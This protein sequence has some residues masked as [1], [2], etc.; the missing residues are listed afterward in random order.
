MKQQVGKQRLEAR[1]V[2]RGDRLVAVHKTEAAEQLDIQLLS[3]RG[4]VHPDPLLA[5]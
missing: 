4:V 5:C 2:Y 1:R 3:V